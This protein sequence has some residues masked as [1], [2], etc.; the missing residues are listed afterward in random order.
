M[1]QLT[2]INFNTKFNDASTGL[3]RDGQGVG[4]ITPEDHRTLATDIKDSFKNLS[5][6]DTIAIDPTVSTE[7]NLQGKN[8]HFVFVAGTIGTTYTWTIAGATYGN[9]F[10]I[11]LGISGGNHA[12]TFPSSFRMADARWNNSTKVW[13]PLEEGIYVGHAFFDGTFWLFEINDS[14]YL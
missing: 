4:A 13:T 11:V 14:P 6:L 10:T 12:Q 5:E 8:N 3:Y 2:A 9:K 1:S 7:I